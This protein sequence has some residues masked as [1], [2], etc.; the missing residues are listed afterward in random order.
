[1]TETKMDSFLRHGVSTKLITAVG[2]H[3]RAIIFHCRIRPEDYDAER[4][5][6][7]IA[8]FL[9]YVIVFARVTGRHITSIS[10]YLNNTLEPY[11][12][13]CELCAHPT[14]IC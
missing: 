9:V 12:Y 4:D 10:S 14:W 1:M 3:M 13:H 6:L 5:L 7:A 11:A 8:T 2:H